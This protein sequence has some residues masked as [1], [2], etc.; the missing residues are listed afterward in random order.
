[1]IYSPVNYSMGASETVSVAVQAEEGVD[2]S[3][4]KAQLLK[5]RS[6][7]KKWLQWRKQSNAVASG[8]I[9]A[10]KGRS[11]ALF[12]QKLRADRLCGEQGLASKL[13]AL[14]SEVFDPASLPTPDVS[15]NPD[16]AAQL[17]L[18]V[19][20]GK[21]P[22][23]SVSP[24]EQGIIWMWPLVIVVGA[25]AFVI[26]SKIRNDAELEM[27]KERTR[28]IQEA[29]WFACDELALVKVGALGIG[30]FYIYNRFLSNRKKRS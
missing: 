9:K 14:L 19:I 5:L 16:A 26:T 20:S 15:Q 28:C 4:A 11:P 2:P 8:K 29:G 17:A 25:V 30:A 6:S 23:E 24:S 12:K 10:K 27:E 21:L 1:M 13:Y 18:I 22:E 3:A 7:L